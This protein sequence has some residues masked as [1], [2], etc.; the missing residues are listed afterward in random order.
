MSSAGLIIILQALA[1]YMGIVSSLLFCRPGLRSKTLEEQQQN[2][3]GMKEEALAAKQDAIGTL[4]GT[5]AEKL[6]NAVKAQKS[7]DVVYNIAG[8]IALLASLA[9]FTAALCLQLQSDPAFHR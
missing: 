2:L 1:T 3:K 4:F 7:A 9:L 8:V 5:A 6:G